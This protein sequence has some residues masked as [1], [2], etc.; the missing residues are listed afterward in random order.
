[1]P[2]HTDQVPDVTVSDGV[3]PHGRLHDHHPLPP[4]CGAPKLFAQWAGDRDESRISRAKVYKT[5]RNYRHTSIPG[6]QR[7]I[8]TMKTRWPS[9]IRETVRG[10]A[11]ANK[12]EQGERDRGE[13]RVLPNQVDVHGHG[14]LG[15][16][17]AE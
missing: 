14:L 2:I 3:S 11:R 17:R 4:L 10:V 13:G 5:M 12:G 16:N 9:W 7:K 6:S 1:M 15:W 8:I